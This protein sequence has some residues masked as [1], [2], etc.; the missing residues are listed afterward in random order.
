MSLADTLTDAERTT[1]IALLKAI[2]EQATMQ[3]DQLK[4]IAFDRMDDQPENAILNGSIIATVQKRKGGSKTRYRVTDPVQYAAWLKRVGAELD[5]TPATTLVTYPKDEC[6]DD[7]YIHMLVEQGGGELPRGVKPVTP[8]AD[9]L[10]VRWAP[11][12]MGRLFAGDL[13]PA[14]QQQ[15]L[16]ER[17]DDDQ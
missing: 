9:S 8:R 5:G 15:L 1:R 7:E 14:F 17:P 10:V 6:T 13:T 2:I 16:E 11:G 3:L 4:P 12:A